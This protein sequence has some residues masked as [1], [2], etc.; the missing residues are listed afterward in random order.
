MSAT[1]IVTVAPAFT[2]RANHASTSGTLRCSVTAVPFNDSGDSAPC[3]GI[4]SLSITMAPL[5]CTAACINFPSGPG[6]RISST[7][8]KAFL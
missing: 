3:S 5:I 4:S 7:A 1:G 2:A 6:R 8:P